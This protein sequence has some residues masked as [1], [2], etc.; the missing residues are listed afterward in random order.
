MQVEKGSMRTL[1]LNQKIGIHSSTLVYDE[2]ANELVGYGGTDAD[3]NSPAFLY[4]L[5]LS[6]K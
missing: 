5:D 4:K 3:S 6:E 2:S 1:S